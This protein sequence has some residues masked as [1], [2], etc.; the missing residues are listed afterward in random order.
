[1]AE[2]VS[3]PVKFSIATYA[4]ATQRHLDVTVFH[5]NPT[6]NLAVDTVVDGSETVEA[7]NEDP[8]VIARAAVPVIAIHSVCPSVGVPLR[9]VVKLVIAVV[10]AVI[11]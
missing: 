1:M 9:L 7:S 2:P 11:E 4:T 8:H 3:Q 5:T 6:S 10:S